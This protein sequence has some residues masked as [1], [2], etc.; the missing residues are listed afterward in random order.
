M[1]IAIPT[2]PWIENWFVTELVQEVKPNDDALVV[3]PDAAVR[4]LRVP[5][6]V[7]VGDGPTKELM[8]VTAVHPNGTFTVDRAYF[9]PD[10]V[11]YAFPAG[12]RVR[13]RL[14]AQYITTLQ[15][16]VTKAY[17]ELNHLLGALTVLDARFVRDGDGAVEDGVLD[18]GGEDPF[19]ELKPGEEKTVRLTRGVAVVG[20]QVFALEADR[21]FDLVTAEFPGA[22]KVAAGALYLTSDRTLQFR[23]GETANAGMEPPAPEPPDEPYIWLGSF[24]LD[25][26][27]LVPES[28]ELP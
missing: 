5:F 27:G 24:E 26:V 9:D 3:T 8:M 22:G 20:G 18:S 2:F 7:V 19:L 28:I 10:P 15:E 13:I 12:T 21:E 17:T 4:A 14:V 11:R 16:A 6:P 23:Y 1:S 25:A